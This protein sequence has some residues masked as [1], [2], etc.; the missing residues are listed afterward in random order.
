M[1]KIQIII[2]SLVFLLS[3]RT[4]TA[5]NNNSPYSIIGIGDI[6]QSYFDRTSGMGHAGIALSSNKFMYQGNPAS[7]SMLDEHF[8]HFE[9]S[10][11]F[12]GVSYSG[13]PINYNNNQSSD[14]QFKRVAMAVKI[15]PKWAT[16]FGLIPF[17]T[18]NYSFYANRTIQ[19]AN[20]TIPAYY[21]GT[22]STNQFYIMNSYK[23]SNTFSVGLQ[24]SYLFGQLK[25]T[26][27][28]SGTGLDSNLVTVKNI[29]LGNPYFKLGVQYR[30]KI[31]TNLKIAVGATA[32][33]QTKL[34]A[35]TSLLVTDGTTTLTNNQN[36]N[37][38]YFTL[39]QIYTAGIAAT[40]KDKYTFAVDYTNQS[41]SDLH[42]RGPGYSLVNS[43]RINA[44]VEY[45]NKV[46]YRD[47]TA[48]KYFLQAGFFYGKSYLNIYG[49]QLDDM[50]VTIGAGKNSSIINSTLSLQGA[51]EIGRRGTTTYGL[52]R[53][54]YVQFTVIIG[55]RDFWL[56]RNFR[57]YD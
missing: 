39:P 7:F 53:E 54:N 1:K 34:R 43:S 49:Q 3:A 30:K 17:G 21:E 44:G 23:F 10:S 13:I 48:E 32:S 11:R 9:V 5:Q 42:Y 37:N 28:I 31:S 16:G 19:G 24:A 50:G 26:E 47:L 6:N 12:R 27:T 35:N 38:N 56:P 22:G 41:W 20:L 45:V 57:R 2:A 36:Y 25:Q 14:I 33:L 18:A 4:A 55:Y 52:I 8:F 40:L 15:K 51:L 29:F 46:R